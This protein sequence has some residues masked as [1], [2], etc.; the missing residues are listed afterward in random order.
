MNGPYTDN[1]SAEP[2]R[3]NSPLPMLALQAVTFAAALYSGITASFLSVVL[4]AFCCAVITCELMRR[5][6]PIPFAGVLLGFVAAGVI[7]FSPF[8]LILPVMF[9]LPAVAMYIMLIKRRDR[10]V[11][12]AVASVGYLIGFVL[13]IVVLVILN[14]GGFSLALLRQVIDDII[15]SL[16][17]SFREMNS[18]YAESGLVIN[19]Q[20]F[21]NIL[22]SAVVSLPGMIIALC[23]AAAYLQSFIVRIVLSKNGILDLLYRDGWLP[24]A[25]FVTA[26]VFV[27]TYI[28]GL[29]AGDNVFHPFFI[30]V[31]NINAVLQVLFGV[32]GFS[33]VLSFAKSR[34]GRSGTLGG[35]MVIGLLF[36]T[37]LFWYLLCISGLAGTV[38]SF[39]KSA[40]KHS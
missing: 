31:T 7:S 5:P 3:K 15:E 17:A 8:V 23:F 14:K 9:V 28:I 37:N 40:K 32:V 1:N 16:S 12:A 20:L 2:I 19:E 26:C 4:A 29:F 18:A 36:F 24:K 39:I 13:V 10:T 25:S 30:T 6:S 21:N 22:K 27:L 34:M 11:T 33:T 35:V 38:A